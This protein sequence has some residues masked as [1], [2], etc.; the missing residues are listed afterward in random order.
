MAKKSKKNNSLQGSNLFSALVSQIS[1]FL[2][3]NDISPEILWDTMKQISGYNFSKMLN[4]NC[5]LYNKPDYSAMV[6]PLHPALEKIMKIDSKT[7]LNRLCD[8]VTEQLKKESDERQREELV[9]ALFWI[10]ANQERFI[11]GKDKEL[12]CNLVLFC[13]LQIMIALDVKDVAEVIIDLLR[14]DD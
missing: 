6:K 4:D 8:E 14:Q 3:N 2:D 12:K 11:V 7:G 5:Y 13:I 9:N 10:L 1:T